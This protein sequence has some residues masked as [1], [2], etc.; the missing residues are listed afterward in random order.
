MQETSSSTAFIELS[1]GT[2]TRSTSP[3]PSA[4]ANE[5]SG[6]RSAADAWAGDASA[7]AVEAAG[8][9]AVGEAAGKAASE[10]PGDAPGGDAVD[11]GQG[12]ARLREMPLRS[13]RG[14]RRGS[15]ERLL[16]AEGAPVTGG[17]CC[18]GA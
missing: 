6:V 4:S 1:S 16:L 13:A 12:G 9:K 5:Y 8:G 7:A 2:S 11:G 14:L 15:G 18:N 17:G 10:A 3:P